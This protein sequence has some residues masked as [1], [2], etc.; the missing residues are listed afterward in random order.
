MNDSARVTNETPEV[1]LTGKQLGDYRILRR[2]GQGG[3]A[4]V[5][6]AEQTS[7]RRRVAWK[8]LRNNL[9]HDDSYLLRFKNEAQAA[10]SLVH[11]NIVQIHEVGCVEGVN[12]IAQE[13]VQGLNLAQYLL[14]K[15]P[16]DVKTGVNILRQ[17]ATALHKSGEQNIIHRDIKPENI[18]L[19]STGEVKVADFGLARVAQDDEV[20]LT[21]VGVTMGTPLYMSP[22]QVEGGG[23]DPRSDIYSLGV[24]CYHMFAGRPPF[25]GD[26]ALAVA[27]QHLQKAPPRLEML[28]PDLPEALCRIVHKMLA[29]A[30]KDRFQRAADLLRELRTLHIEGQSHDPHEDWGEWSTAELLALSDARLEATQ[31][32]DAIMKSSAA[33]GGRKSALYVTAVVLL[34]AFLFGAAGAWWRRP[35][36]LLYVDAQDSSQV[37]HYET[38]R[39][40]YINTLFLSEDELRPAHWE[41]VWKRFDPQDSMNLMWAR[42]AK[43]QLALMYLKSDELD[44]ALPLFRELADLEEEEKKFRAIGL[45]GQLLVQSRRGNQDEVRRLAIKLVPLRDQ[46]ENSRWLA[47]QVDPYLDEIR[48]AVGNDEA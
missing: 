13:Y 20:N 42:L 35:P 14:R 2:L 44:S 32:L 19:S 26:N 34:A 15:G 6:L 10:A 4:V 36:D 25:E 39:E 43:Q 7:L 18:M 40:Q 3:M 27:V 45:A 48:Q 23:I 29:K 46:I 22:E 47:A 28:R 41:A 24:T 37:A 1:N 21:Q 8:V 33:P 11:A 12:Y 30:P 31:Q 17:V 5:Y 16:V 9:A 38:A